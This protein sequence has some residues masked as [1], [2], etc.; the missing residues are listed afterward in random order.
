MRR[1]WLRALLPLALWASVI[2]ATS[3]TFIDRDTFIGWIVPHLPSV[4]RHSFVVCWDNL[5][6]LI[7]VKGYHMAEFSLLFLLCRQLLHTTGI[8]V[9]QAG[10]AS[11]FLCFLYAA[12][13]EYHQTFVPGRGGTW[14]DVA[15]D[16]VGIAIAWLLVSLRIRRAAAIVPAVERSV[17]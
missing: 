12:S 10:T 16:S 4:F 14:Y 6:G 9:R 7:V 1:V 5:G 8:A 11:A 3:C 17:G 13:D 2:F 15:I